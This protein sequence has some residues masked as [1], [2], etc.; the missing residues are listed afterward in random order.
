MSFV[1]VRLPVGIERGARRVDDEDI[2]IVRSDA[3]TETRNARHDQ[4][5]R[6]W[7]FSL[8]TERLNTPGNVKAL[9]TMWKVCRKSLH[10]F[11]WRDWTAFQLSDE[12]IGT[13]DG[14]DTTFQITKTW[15]LGGSSYVERIT[16]PSRDALI[17][18]K[19]A[20]VVQSPS[21]YSVNYLTGVITFNSAPGNGQ[22]ITVSCE[23]DIAVRF[24]AA[25]TSGLEH[26]GTEKIDAVH[27]VEVF[28]E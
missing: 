11:R 18:V 20:G 23:Y 6:E 28:N 12:L 3:G 9:R 7:E 14:S 15:S 16:K 2:E 4:S 8:A 26:F 27:L 10:S 19:K 22:A 13:G 24:D 21:A 1:D 25:L 5:A 17:T